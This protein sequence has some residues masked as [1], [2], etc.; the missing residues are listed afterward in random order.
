[1]FVFQ[2]AFVY[3]LFILLLGACSFDGITE[4]EYI[5]KAEERLDR[6]DLTGA[7]I[8]VKNALSLNPANTRARWLLATTLLR[9]GDGRGAAIHYVKAMEQGI[10]P[11]S[12]VHLLAEAYLLAKDYQKSLALTA[13]RG[14]RPE[15]K[16]R[17]LS[18][19]ALSHMF[20][21]DQQNALRTARLALE[22]DPN[23]PYA[24]TAM[25][26]ILLQEGKLKE[27]GTSLDK[28][29]TVDNRYALAWTLRGDLE[30][31]AGD[32][33][34]ARSSYS[35]A[36][37]NRFN[38]DGDLL[39]RAL[40]ALKM[41]DVQAAKNDLL[42]L[43]KKVPDSYWVA[44]LSGV[45][46]MSEKRYAEAQAE[47]ETTLSKNEQ[48]FDARLY[49][50]V[51]Q[52]LQ[53]QFEQAERNIST[54]LA[55]QPRRID[56]HRMLAAVY[57]ARGDAQKAEQTIRPVVDFLPDDTFSISLL[58]E[59]LIRQGKTEE[60]LTQMERLGEIDPNSTLTQ[61]RVAASL[62][63]ARHFD[64]AI[65]RLRSVTDADPSLEINQTMLVYAL[66]KRGMLD[67]ALVSASSYQ[68][69]NPNSATALN[70]LG[71]VLMKKGNVEEAEK[72][73]IKAV[74]LDPKIATAR[75]N[76][77][78]I[79]SGKSQTNK[80]REQL[81]SILEERKGHL[82]ASLMLAE[83]ERASGHAEKAESVLLLAIESNPS[84][85]APQIALSRLWLE[86]EKHD[87][88][89]ELLNKNYLPKQNVDILALL[90]EAYL[91][92]GD[93]RAAQ[94]TIE[95]AVDLRP[96][97]AALLYKLAVAYTLLGDDA[98]MSS[99][100]ERVLALDPNHIDARLAILRVQVSKGQL[101]EAKA[102]LSQNGNTGQR[103]PSLLLLKGELALKQGKKAEALSYFQEGLNIAPSPITLL[104]L[105][106]ALAEQGRLADAINTLESWRAR[107]PENIAVSVSLAN[108]LMEMGF[109]EKASQIY[110]DVLSKDPE[111][112]LALNNIAWIKM[113][114]NTDKALEYAERAV[115]ISPDSP[116][117]LDTLAVAL[118]SRQSYE[119]ALQ[120]I[121]R[122]LL[123]EPN[124][125]TYNYRK[126]MILFKLG[127]KNKALEAIRIALGGDDRAFPERQEAESLYNRISSN[128]N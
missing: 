80:A 61:S 123:K 7:A 16:A 99:T 71:M 97:D 21:R 32:L 38:N 87:K 44:Y 70:T 74:E 96:S 106:N 105:A 75:L 12:S 84:D 47:F 33:T 66:I 89:I 56:A 90:G 115:V 65:K 119:R 120:T 124:S 25:G 64:E 116:Q 49:L 62:L 121:D 19:Q 46:L 98:L 28:A 31:N 125:G 57:A 67:E 73:F 43:R 88:V 41:E 122:A 10:A 58:A 92:T 18:S 42:T 20:L 36:I 3:F 81:Q 17:L 113:Q 79:A 2:R 93:G 6:G 63:D 27:A 100:L 127:E 68:K 51:A 11:D 24:H 52:L 103:L 82:L 83:I 14:W 13:E 4:S 94:K 128:R 1:M 8:E 108:L 77:A 53:G 40:L 114:L 102:W 111:N 60:G 34:S 76:L 78:R 55:N 85:P 126:A 118:F 29:L 22:V 91:R 15:V 107:S 95:T 72:A 50:G 45:I 109:Q 101:D 104:A 86:N 48:L 69:R 5:S 39:K 117:I 59:A 35:K 110:E 23:S 112:T 30:Q 37:E 9:R 54:V 26:W